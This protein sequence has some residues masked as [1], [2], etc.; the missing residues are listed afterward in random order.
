MINITHMLNNIMNTTCSKNRNNYF[1]SNND[2]Y[3]VKVLM[4]KSPKKKKGNTP[5]YFN[6]NYRRKM[7][8]VSII[9]DYCLL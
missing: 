3:N 5:I 1:R 8:L 6:A 7:K 9:M 4:Y 2:Q